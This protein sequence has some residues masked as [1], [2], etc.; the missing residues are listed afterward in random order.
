MDTSRS[1][2][3]GQAWA[4]CASTGSYWTWLAIIVV[5]TIGA[6]VGIK[7]W[8]NKQNKDLDKYVLVAAIIGAMAIACAIF[9]RP[10]QVA[11]NTSVNM[12]AKGHYLGY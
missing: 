9:G 1:I 3:F 6:I 12:A 2:T 4:H 7:V 11:A 5:L 8:A 10:A